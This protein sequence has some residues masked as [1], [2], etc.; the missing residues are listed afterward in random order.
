[1]V[2]EAGG[3]VPIDVGFKSSLNN[4]ATSAQI[5]QLPIR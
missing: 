3:S 2:A 1:M 4:P 5:G